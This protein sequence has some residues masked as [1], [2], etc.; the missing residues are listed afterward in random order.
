M[1]T[2]RNYFFNNNKYGNPFNNDNAIHS[3]FIK[4]DSNL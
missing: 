2:Y 3:L 1:V 4:E